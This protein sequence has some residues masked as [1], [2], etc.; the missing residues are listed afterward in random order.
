M[1]HAHGAA[2]PGGEPLGLVHRDVSPQN[3]LVSRDGVPKLLDFGVA[4]ARGRLTE[5]QAGTLKGKL[6]YMAPERLSGSVDHRADLFAV[7]VCLFE[8]TTG[9][10]PYGP[11]VDDEVALLALPGIGRYTAAAIRA[12]AFDQPASAV[13]GNVERVIARL[14][15]IETP[16][17]DAKPEI[18]ARAETEPGRRR[19]RDQ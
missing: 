8:A 17:P 19:D 13:D 4:K 6:R 16:L 2:G 1:H 7:G 5:T 12:I 18:Q 14:Y 15:A 9:Q 3:I 11:E 10:S